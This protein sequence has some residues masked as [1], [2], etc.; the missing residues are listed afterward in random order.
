M[1]S[2]PPVELPHAATV[3]VIE[4][5]WND[6]VERTCEVCPKKFF[7]YYS[8]IKRGKGRTCSRDCARK[9]GGIVSKRKH[10]QVGSANPNYKGGVRKPR[11]ISKATLQLRADKLI[12]LAL[13][14]K[15]IQKRPCHHCGSYATSRPVGV[16]LKFPLEPCSI[17]RCF[18]QCAKPE[19]A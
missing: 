11:E 2:L 4:P 14:R 17:W 13:R 7:A 12:G 6:Q 8:D 10:S 18:P 15:W 1:D 19:A 16:D 9:L 5:K 3:D